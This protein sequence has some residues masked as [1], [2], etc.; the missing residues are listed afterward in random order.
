M[1]LFPLLESAKS[2]RA[3]FGSLWFDSTIWFCLEFSSVYFRVQAGTLLV[4]PQ[5]FFPPQTKTLV[6]FLPRDVRT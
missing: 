1:L 4:C 6:H 2:R 3:F 5:G